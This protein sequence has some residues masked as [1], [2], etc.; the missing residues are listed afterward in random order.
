MWQFCQQKAT[1][2][3]VLEINIIYTNFNHT[4]ANHD[5]SY[6]KIHKMGIEGN[7]L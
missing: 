4:N 6:S 3:K 1:V 2:V 7:D 5:G